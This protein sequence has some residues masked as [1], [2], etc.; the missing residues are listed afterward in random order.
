MRFRLELELADPARNIL[1]INYQYELGSW[2]YSVIRHGDPRFA[3]WLHRNGY[4]D[5]NK[6]FRLFTFSNLFIPRR[7]VQGDRLEIQSSRIGLIISFF[8]EEAITPFIQGLFMSS[9]FGLGDNRSQADFRVSSVEAQPE[10]R[11]SDTLTINLISP[12]LVSRMVP[13]EKYARYLSPDQPG[14]SEMILRNLEEKWKIYTCQPLPGGKTTSFELLSPFRKKG[15]LIKSG[16]PMETKLI[17]YLFRFRL[18]APAPLLRLGYYTGFGEKNSMGFGCP[19]LSPD[20]TFQVLK[21]WKV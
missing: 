9:E 10:P 20:K 11:I 5:Q 17:G 7:A 15:V 2:I 21:T 14:Y 8:P 16:T 18:T 12:L 6:R 13:G 4:A 1:P 3:T 19:D